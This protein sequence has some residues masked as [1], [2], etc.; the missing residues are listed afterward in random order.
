M[1]SVLAAA[2]VWHVRRACI[3]EQTNACLLRRGGRRAGLPCGGLIAWLTLVCWHFNTA[4]CLHSC[5]AGRTAPHERPRLTTTHAA[6][7]LAG[8]VLLVRW[9]LAWFA[10]TLGVGMAQAKRRAADWRLARKLLRCMDM[11][12]AFIVRAPHHRPAATSAHFT[13]DAH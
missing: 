11:P 7:R 6:A 8:R 4:S 13:S 2:G 12:A 9:W 1:P 10:A 3:R 5:F